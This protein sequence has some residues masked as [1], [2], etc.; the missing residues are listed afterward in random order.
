MLRKLVL[1]VIA[2]AILLYVVAY[3][4]GKGWFADMGVSQ[5]F[6]EFEDSSALDFENFAPYIGVMKNIVALDDTTFYARY[7][8]QRI[9]TGSIGDSEYSAQRV[10]VGLQKVLF[11]TP[12]QQLSAGVNAAYDL[13][14]GPDA[15]ERDEYAVELSYSYAITHK[16]TATLMGRSAIWNFDQGGRDDRVHIAG[17]DLSYNLN[18]NTTVSAGVY[19]TNNDSNTPFG[20]NDSQSWQGGLSVGLNHT[21]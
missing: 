18:E 13:S 15:L 17:L 2:A 1:F 4:A 12:R 16:L 14:A 11:S 3:G 20:V 21:F 9:T 6:Y 8:Y 5:E 10:R 19:Y 7:E